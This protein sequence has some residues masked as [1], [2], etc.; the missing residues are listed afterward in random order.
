MPEQQATESEEKKELNLQVD[1]EEVGPCKRK[2]KVVVAQEDVKAKID[3]SY[4]ELRRTV[5]VPG[6]RIGHVPRALLERRFGKDIN[7]EVRHTLIG[8]SFR[9]ALEDHKLD[10]IGTPDFGEQPEEP[11]ALEPDKPLEYDVTVEVKPDFDIE[12]YVGL[13]VDKHKVAVKDEHIDQAVENYRMQ[14]AEPEE[15]TEEATV[16]A[17]DYVNCDIAIEVEEMEPIRREKM[18]IAVSTDNVIGIEIEGLADLMAGAKAGDARDV[19]ITLPDTFREQ[20]YRGKE[21]KVTLTVNKIQ[22]LKLPEVNDEWAQTLRFD[23][24]ADMR[25]EMSRQLERRFQREIEAAMLHQVLEKV[26]ELV[27]FEL[28][29][30]IVENSAESRQR[31]LRIGLSQRGMDEEAIEQEIEKGKDATHEAAVR[32]LKMLFILDKIAEKEKVFATEDDVKA[33]IE[34]MAA[35]YRVTPDQL[36]AHL[37]KEDGMADLRSQIREDKVRQFL[38]EKAEKI[39]VDEE[40]PD[41]DSVR[42]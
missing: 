34:S 16:E 38:L 5:P 7:Q 26:G 22:R 20:D 15:V 1:I 40:L 4:V 31:R 14:F 35:S 18:E 12:G 32:D 10:P 36:R 23:S 42:S 24:V 30:D 33:A 37:E 6:F 3:E 21:A 2:I 13:K 25:E 11:P 27:D 28:P 41:A 8:D 39:E 29:A 19:T 17:N 9:K